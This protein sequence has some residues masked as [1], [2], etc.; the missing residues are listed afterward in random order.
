MKLSYLL[1]VI[2]IRKMENK[3]PKTAPKVRH[4]I[5]KPLGSGGPMI[6]P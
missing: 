4:P 3:D 5:S 6:V 1:L 2:G